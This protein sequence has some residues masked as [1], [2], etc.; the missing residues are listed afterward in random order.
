MTREI[1]DDLARAEALPFEAAS[2]RVAETH[3]SWVF[4]GDRDVVKVKK[5]KSLGF[6]DFSTIERRR[7]ACEAEVKLNARL[8]PSVYLGVLPVR[9]DAGGRATLRGE[10]EIIDYAVHMRRLPDE[11]SALAKIEAGALSAGDVDAVAERMA[12]FHAAAPANLALGTVRSIAENVAENFA[13]AGRD[14]ER[15][16]TRAEEEEIERWQGSL[17]AERA[18]LFEARRASG[19]V[20]D[21]HGDLRLEHV[22]FVDGEVLVIDCIE[23]DERFRVGDVASDVAFFAMD[24]ARLGRVDLAERF[25][26]RYATVTGDFDLYGVVDFYESYRAYVRAKV[27]IMLTRDAGAPLETRARAEQEARRYLTLALSADR[28]SLLSPVLVAVGGLIASGKSTVA[29]L[30]GDWLAAPVVEADR[31]RKNMLGKPH[32][33]FLGTGT[34][35]GAYD[36]AFTERVYD[37]V[38]RRAGVV[39]ASGRPVV[40]DASFRSRA[41]RARLLE[42]A[43]SHGVPARFVECRADE[44]VIRARLRSREKGPSV[45]DGREAVFDE[46]R[47]RFEAFSELSPEVHVALDT[48]APRGELESKLSEA[49]AAWPKGLRS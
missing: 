9:L 38:L 8:A 4:L 29:A 32:T 16:V 2:V 10:G 19:R 27:A 25:L 37:E 44:D 34:W 11:A 21:G 33:E 48:T 5:P 17:L 3:V 24:L 39:L 42:L 6:L 31:T 46:F 20:R 43:R 7:A 47:A 30:V 41:Q 14:A 23:F 22:Y 1:R 49:V 18:D 45:S 13:Q 26:A 36:P 40:V 28:R 35:S 12:S 15:F